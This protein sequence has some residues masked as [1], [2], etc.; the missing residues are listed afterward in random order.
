[1]VI[2]VCSFALVLDP[3]RG[4]VG[5]GIGSAGPTPLRAAEAER[6]L[7]GVLDEQGLWTSR[8]PIG[9]AAAARFGELGGQ[10]LRAD[11]RRQGHG[12]LAGPCPRGAG[13]PDPRLGLGAVPD[14]EELRRCA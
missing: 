5:T 9:V 7:Q 13:P 2:A 11:R 8:S 3:E 14:Q 6:F 4:Q 1:M 12:R 10:G